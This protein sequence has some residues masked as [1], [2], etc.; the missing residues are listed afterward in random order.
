MAYF[1]II[2]FKITV[3]AMDGIIRKIQIF[4]L[5]IKGKISLMNKLNN[6]GP[7]I[8]RYGTNLTI[9][10]KLLCDM[11]FVF[12]CCLRFDKQFCIR[13]KPVLSI[14]LSLNFSRQT[15]S[16]KQIH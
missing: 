9:S 13:F 8:E 7:K 12:V 15:I 11:L 10:Y 2:L 16:S 3:T 1:R 4:V 14:P 5:L 6:N